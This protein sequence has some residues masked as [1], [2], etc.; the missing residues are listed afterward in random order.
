MFGPLPMNTPL[1]VARGIAQA[2]AD[3]K[4][5]GIFKVED[6]IDVRENVLG[7]G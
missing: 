7:Y 6:N 5:N 1:S 2:C 4:L 3:D